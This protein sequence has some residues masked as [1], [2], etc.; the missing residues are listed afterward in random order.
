L[1][2][3]NVA[4]PA[5]ILCGGI[6]VQDILMRVKEFPAPGTKVSASDYVITGGGCAANAAVAIARLGGRA[7]FSGPLGGD[8][9]PVTQRIIADLMGEKVDAAHVVRVAGATA[10]VSLILI[11]AAGEKTIATRRGKNLSLARPANAAA[12]VAESDVLLIDNRFPEFVAALAAAAS[13]RKIP[14]VIDVDKATT[15]DDALLA[16]GTHLIF[17]ADAL[18]DTT[19]IAN[20]AEALRSLRERFGGLLSVTDGAAGVF[21]LDGKTVRHEA[22]F[23][24]EAIDTLGAGDTFHGAFALYLAEGNEIAATMRFASAAAAIKCERFG[25]NAG[26]PTR[27]EVEDFLRQRG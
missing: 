19:G 13:T 4:K 18:R 2:T 23:P 25:G 27:I 15:P 8:G 20:R 9:D 12:A 21:W 17:S 24:V 16:H 1:V 5:N 22:A 10:S 11:D 26:T 6:A 7:A 3:N 14:V